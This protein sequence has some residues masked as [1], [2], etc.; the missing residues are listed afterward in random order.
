MNQDYWNA[1]AQRYAT[2]CEV[3]AWTWH[4]LNGASYQFFYRT[5]GRSVH[6][7]VNELQIGIR[8]TTEAGGYVYFFDEPE[9][10]QILAMSEG[11]NCQPLFDI[12]KRLGY[13]SPEFLMLAIE[14]GCTV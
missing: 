11:M 5:E 13:D 3:P 1:Q 8:L 12:A 10:L 4:K 6:I 7:S 2:A 9:G 14:H